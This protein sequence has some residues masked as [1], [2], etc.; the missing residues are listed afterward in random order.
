MLKTCFIL[1]YLSASLLF[2]WGLQAQEIESTAPDT[3]PSLLEGPQQ[4]IL[5]AN[6]EI[7]QEH[8]AFLA[9]ML[10]KKETLDQLQ[11][12]L[13]L[14]P[15]NVENT[16]TAYIEVSRIWSGS[17][18]QLADFFSDINLE[19]QVQL[20]RVFA[21]EPAGAE[22]KTAYS[23]YLLSFKKLRDDQINFVNSRRT[24]L[25][26]LK[27][28]DFKILQDSGILRAKLLKQ[29]Q[30][31]D[32]DQAV[33]LNSFTL[34]LL[35]REMKAVP[36]KFT[37]GALSKWM[38]I[39]DKFTS[40]IDGWI[41]LARQ[42]FI[43]FILLL[44][45]F[46]L[47]KIFH[48]LTRRLDVLKR[49]LLARSDMEYQRRTLLALWIGRVNPFVL[50]LGMIASIALARKMIEGTDLRELSLLLFY[51]QIYFLYRFTEV[52][53][54]IFLEILFATRSMDA[55]KRQK[56][57]IGKSATRI[58][59]L[60]FIEYAILHLTQ[61][62]V[63]EALA[64]HLFEKVI[65]WINLFFVFVESNKWKTEIQLGFDERYPS[66]AHRIHGFKTHFWGFIL[67]PF[68]FVLVALHHSVEVISNKLMGFDFVKRLMSEVFRKQLE[69]F[70]KEDEAHLL[71]PPPQEYLN[72]F[73][74]F[75]PTT[76]DTFVSAA[77]SPAPDMIEEIK[78]WE[79]G[80]TVQ[81]L[82]LIV[83]NRGL[84]KTTALTYVAHQVAS[85]SLHVAVAITPPKI[86][87]I[88]NLYLWLSETLKSPVL[89]RDDLRKLDSSLKARLFVAV[90]DIHNLFLGRVGGF[91]AY[92]EF[93]DILNS[94]LTNICWGLTVNSRA[95][96]LLKGVIGNEHFSGKI[97]TLKS[98]K[99][100]EIQ[101]LIIQ[102]H[103]TTGFSR[104]FDKNIAAYGAQDSFGQQVEMQFFRLLWGQARGNPHTAL[105][106]WLSAISLRPG[107]SI[108]VGIPDFVSSTA[109]SE[110][111]DD[112]LFTLSAL[113]RHD[114]L[115]LAELV[116]VTEI[117][118]LTLRK[119]IK[120]ALDKELIWQ[121]SAARL[122]VAARAQYVI[123]YY[124]VGKNFLYE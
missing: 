84:G 110:M 53:F 104:S 73:D 11:G 56:E 116:L 115:N 9:K 68:M 31:T 60:I 99:D 7:S 5:A 101:N 87:Q 41:D 97:L 77:G 19:S 114:S 121:D 12:Q 1:L 36:L 44:I 79:S 50:S 66:L 117:P 39:R 120:E 29:C 95:W 10:K 27:L 17:V 69:R 78:S 21:F 14:I 90:D 16:I 113:A 100:F 3:Q 105:M 80:E 47:V 67:L 48:W 86:T 106:H 74:Y 58:A 30:F 93:L 43:L 35:L 123:D 63:R 24:L 38:E 96:T 34:G 22:E 119:C 62:T 33:G 91:N 40:G 49:G 70:D 118:E 64:Y 82:F 6:S 20:P 111:S 89:S 28:K 124:L 65:F 23:Q 46:V 18:D 94:P 13:D 25:D 72:A 122:R 8:D 45:P 37:V 59:R 81:N 103:N 71:T 55:A 61:D 109:V 75:A 54:E 92:R 76:K 98:W 42:G 52:L 2:T 85:E 108:H 26:E 4:E 102:R 88:D 57:A 32:C 51:L 15:K 112:A 83:G 107:K